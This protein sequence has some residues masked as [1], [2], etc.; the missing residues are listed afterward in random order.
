[1][2]HFGKSIQT[3]TY[4]DYLFDYNNY[5]LFING[6]VYYKRQTDLKTT[7]FFIGKDEISDRLAD[8]FREIDCKVDF[9]IIEGDR[10]RIVG[11]I[12]TEHTVIFDSP[13]L[14]ISL[15]KNKYKNIVDYDIT[16]EF[17]K[18]NKSFACFIYDCISQLL[19]KKNRPIKKKNIYLYKKVHWR[20]MGMK[21][22]KYKNEEEKLDK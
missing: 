10:L 6:I 17:N 15:N 2:N 12:K 3:V 7:S 16:I 1:M 14:K 8:Q 20:I 4:V 13:D 11:R 18:K 21:Y 9:S 22:S 5:L 19:N